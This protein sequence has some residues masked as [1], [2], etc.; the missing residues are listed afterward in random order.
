M[1]NGVGLDDFLDEL[2]ASGSGGSTPHLVLGDGIPVLTVDGEENPHFWLDPTL[3]KQYYVPAIAAR[4]AELDPDG[5]ATYD[6]NARRTAR[7][8]TPSTRSSRP[9]SR[10]S[11]RRTASSS[12]STMRSRTSPS[13]TASRWSAS[14]LENVGQEPTAGELAALVETVKAA[15]VKAIFCEA[16]FSPE[17][18]QT[19]AEEAGVTT[20][21]TTLYN[22]ALGPA[23]AD[24]YVG[25]MRWNVDQIVAALK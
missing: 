10:R 18:A 20:I 3:V 15:G 21:V 14:I 12:R 13:T 25:L 8:S 9:R 6:A 7:P 23:P 5:K 2:L 19:L 16:Q 11:R 17:L 1:S 24:T 22:D 4:L